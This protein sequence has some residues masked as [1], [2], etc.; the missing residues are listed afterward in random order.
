MDIADRA[1]ASEDGLDEAC[2][3]SLFDAVVDKGSDALI[4][5]VILLDEI[6]GFGVADAQALRETEGCL[7][8]DDSEIDGF[9]LAALV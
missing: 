5:L 7:A 9:G 8:V 6:V 2:F 4:S 1:S 3:L